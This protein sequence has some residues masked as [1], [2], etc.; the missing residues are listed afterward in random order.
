MSAVVAITS[1]SGDGVACGF[2]PWCDDRADPPAD[3][4]MLPLDELVGHGRCAFSAGRSRWASKVE[5][6]GNRAAT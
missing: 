3:S 6:W 5:R 1:R 4:G 2:R